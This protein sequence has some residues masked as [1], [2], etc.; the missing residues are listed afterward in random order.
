MSFA[1]YCFDYDGEKFPGLRDEGRN[2]KSI[3][4]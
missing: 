3:F 2:G 1:G 4:K